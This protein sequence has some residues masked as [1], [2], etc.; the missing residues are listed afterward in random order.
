MSKLRCAVVLSLLMSVGVAAGPAQ[1]RI[2]TPE[3]EGN[4][5]L[6]APFS[7]GVRVQQVWDARLFPAAMRIDALTFF[8]NF[9]QSAESYIEPAHY[10]FFLSVTDASSDTVTTDF[11]ANHGRRVEEVAEMMVVGTST[12]F[13]DGAFGTLTLELSKAFHYNPRK[14]NLLLEIQKDQSSCDG[15]GPIYVDGSSDADGVT[16]VTQEF[17]I[18]PHFGMTV[19]FDGK[20]HG[21]GS[22]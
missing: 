14:G 15:D 10:R 17:G 19:G 20:L 4:I 21:E 18:F 5:G 1:D 16:L 9:P 7:C 12:G 6:S 2:V 11:E 8:N 3:P 22:D 13:S